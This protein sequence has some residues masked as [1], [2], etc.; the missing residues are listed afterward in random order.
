MNFYSSI[1]TPFFFVTCFLKIS[2]VFEYS[3][4]KT[5]L[6]CQINGTFCGNT[7]GLIEIP[8]ISG[9]FF[10]FNFHLKKVLTLICR[11]K[12]GKTFPKYFKS[13]KKGLITKLSKLQTFVNTFF[14]IPIRFSSER[15]DRVV[16]TVEVRRSGF[17]S[18]STTNQLCVTLNYSFIL[19]GPY[20]LI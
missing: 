7:N 17:L 18:Q 1:L 4:P 14:P 8:S 20:F 15:G 16:P 6:L 9:I 13:L 10:S 2:S 3:N 11:Y 19:S 12:I 5:S